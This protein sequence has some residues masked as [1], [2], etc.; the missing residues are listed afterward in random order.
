MDEFSK[1]AL[2][3]EYK[4]GLRSVLDILQNLNVGNNP[5]AAA[6]LQALQALVGND[7]VYE[8]E[9]T[10]FTF[11]IPPFSMQDHVAALGAIH[12]QKDLHYQDK[13][14]VL[15]R[16]AQPASFPERD[17]EA[18]AHI[19]RT[20]LLNTNAN[21]TV[22]ELQA[23]EATA[24]AQQEVRNRGTLTVPPVWELL[25][26]EANNDIRGEDALLI[27]TDSQHKIVD[28][29]AVANN[30][31]QFG[32]PLGYTN[33][34]Y[35]RA[36]DRFVGFF[37]PSL[38]AVT[39]NLEAVE[40]A[41][42][43][44]RTSIPASKFERLTNQMTTLVRQPN[45]PLKSTLAQLQGMALAY[46]NDKPIAERQSSVNRIMIQ[47]LI[48]FT[49]GITNK[50]LTN[51]ISLTQV[52]GRTCQWNDLLDAVINSERIHGTPQTPLSFQPNLRSSVDLFHSTYAPVE[53][54]I[55]TEPIPVEYP[56]NPNYDFYNAPHYNDQQNPHIND[57]RPAIHRMRPVNIP[58]QQN[59][60][61]RPVQV[62]IVPQ[63]GNNQAAP[64]I[65]PPQPPMPP[66]IP[67][68]NP[69][70]PAIPKRQDHDIPPPP[71]PERHRSASPQPRRS[72]RKKQQ[73][74]NYDAQ[75]GAY[76]HNITTQQPRQ[77]SSSPS[78]Q[79]QQRSYSQ[80]RDNK[81]QQPRN[82]QYRSPSRDR[83][84]QNQMNNG[85]YNN[86]NNSPYRQNNQSQNQGYQNRSPQTSDRRSYSDNRYRSDSRNRGPSR[87][88]RYRDQRQ[89]SPSPYR[90]NNNQYNSSNRQSRSDS[91]RYRD[92]RQQ[93]PR[94]QEKSYQQQRPYSPGRNDQRQ[95]S[96]S[97]Y[98]NNGY[99]PINS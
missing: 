1:Q 75:A 58:V 14:S 37:S 29:Y 5:G 78:R 47:G 73:A 62:P 27:F 79:N 2:T 20:A 28:W 19:A 18:A 94:S 83:Y 56:Y 76:I 49:T 13:H 90:N 36:L 25:Q 38:K 86:R 15:Y 32:E 61:H 7:D 6:P 88:N 97:P 53:N 95:R 8:Q 16:N 70:P 72:S 93:R 74:M 68:P 63:L 21:A 44:M 39:D 59:P 60:V 22:A 77:Y 57:S 24:R 9:I 67:A 3:A 89:R 10:E 50:Y 42:F 82:N 4:N 30:L 26:R 17:P 96:Q 64:L 51:Q 35:K 40:L 45:M 33:Q 31:R 11:T 81:S 54:G 43:L 99:Q 71:R 84:S 69:P 66:P 34:H 48:S 23:A 85:S 92:Y 80:S 46:Y 98:R 65:P 52:Q 41:Q 91:Q 55:I 12:P 87:D